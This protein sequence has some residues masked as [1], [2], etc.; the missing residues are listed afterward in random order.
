MISRF[1]RSWAVPQLL[2]SMSRSLIK[3]TVE[4]VKQSVTAASK[5]DG[6][7]GAAGKRHQGGAKAV[8]QQQQQQQQFGR[9]SSTSGA[10]GTQELL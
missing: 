7:A 1:A 2:R 6:L 10:A 8:Q 9:D 4:A 3:Q 5:D